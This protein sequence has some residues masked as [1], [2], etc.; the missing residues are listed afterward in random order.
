M[1]E[2]R[3]FESDREEER[4]AERDLEVNPDVIRDLEVPDEDAG[5]IAGASLIRC[6]TR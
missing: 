3:D 6:D 4:H 1:T 5:H 2:P